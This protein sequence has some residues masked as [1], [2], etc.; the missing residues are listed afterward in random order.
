M[1][2]DTMY[3]CVDC[4]RIFYEP[5]VIRHGYEEYWGAVVALPDGSG[6]PY[7]RSEEVEIACQ[8]AE[9][10]GYFL[11]EDLTELEGALLC[12]DCY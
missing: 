1:Q 10:D 3:I 6:C 5:A 4:K 11:R 8:C 2:T 12:Q 9:C 7:C